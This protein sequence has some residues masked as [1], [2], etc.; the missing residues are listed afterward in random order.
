MEIEPRARPVGRT[1]MNDHAD[2]CKVVL[3]WTKA[4]KLNVYT[5]GP[6]GWKMETAK[7]VATHALSS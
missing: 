3:E 1:D 2:Y 4:L 5:M 6:P 7:K